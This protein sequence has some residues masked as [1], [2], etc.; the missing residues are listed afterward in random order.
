MV[1]AHGEPRK[2]KMA[3]SVRNSDAVGELA[4]TMPI[5]RI[6]AGWETFTVFAKL[7]CRCQEIRGR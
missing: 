5:L 3:K 1:K 4:A 6:P 2:W 7:D